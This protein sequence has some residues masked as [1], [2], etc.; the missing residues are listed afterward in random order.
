MFNLCTMMNRVIYGHGNGFDLILNCLLEWLIKKK[1]LSI[2]HNLYFYLVLSSLIELCTVWLNVAF[3]TIYSWKPIETTVKS[4]SNSSN[5]G[6]FALVEPNDSSVNLRLLFSLITF[7]S[8]S[9]GVLT[10]VVYSVPLFPNTDF[11]PQPLTHC[12]TSWAVS[13]NDCTLWIRVFEVVVRF[14]F[15]LLN[16]WGNLSSRI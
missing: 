11:H 15:K 5:R 4:H 2:R 3:N 9:S 8:N 13:K 6:V 1:Q 7:L 14:L 12:L 10:A 16:S